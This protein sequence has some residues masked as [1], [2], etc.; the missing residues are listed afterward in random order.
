MFRAAGSSP[1]PPNILV[2]LGRV[3]R[4]VDPRPKHS[5]DVGVALVESIVDDVMDER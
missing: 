1:D 3:L 5:S 2:A 4:K